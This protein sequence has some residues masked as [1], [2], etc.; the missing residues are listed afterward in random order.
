MYE[1]K[2]QDSISCLVVSYVGETMIKKRESNEV[3]GREFSRYNFNGENASD[4]DVDI[5]LRLFFSQFEVEYMFLYSLNG[6]IG[7]RYVDNMY[8]IQRMFIYFR[9]PKRKQKY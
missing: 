6:I 3:K 5:K 8:Q 7:K 1:Y 9:N 4:A 2:C